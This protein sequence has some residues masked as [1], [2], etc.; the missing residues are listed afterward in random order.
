MPEHAK[1]QPSSASRWLVCP[2]SVELC[3]SVV[4]TGSEYADE[5]TAGHA[6]F[7][8]LI[9]GRPVPEM[10]NVDGR[11]IKVT[12]ELL[13]LVEPCVEWA[14]DYK[15]THKAAIFSEKKYEIGEGFGLKAGLLWGTADFTAVSASELCIADLKLG[16]NDVPVKDNKQLILYALGAL[17]ATGWM[18]EKIRLV[19]LQP[20]TADEPKEHVYTAAELEA[21]QD[22]LRPKVLTAAKGG[23]LVATEEG[24]R[25]CKAAGTCPELRRE[26]LAL[27]QREMANLITLSGD[28]IADLLNKGEMIENALKAVRSHAIRLL[29]LDPAAVPGYKRVLGRKLRV[30]TA[31]PKEVEAKVKAFKVDVYEKCLRSPAQVEASL[32]ENLIG[33]SEGAP[34]DEGSKKIK[35]KKHAKEVAKRLLSPFMEVP[36]GEPTLVKDLDPRHALGPIFTQEDVQK[37]LDSATEDVID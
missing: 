35:T 21:F 18:H 25:W 10:V 7:E 11:P 4:D 29:E 34:L 22:E 16:F 9:T 33:C 31:E 5:G 24:C 32:A 1:L 27:A 17:D 8:A 20:K 36:T 23:P 3:S 13:A 12:P 37:A 30:W 6:A 26:T 28:E 2:G 19:I 14:L 15:K